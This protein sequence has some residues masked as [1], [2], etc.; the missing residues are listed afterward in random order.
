VGAAAAGADFAAFEREPFVAAFFAV[1]VFRAGVVFLDVAEVPA[2]F[3]AQRFFKAATIAALPA[4]LIFRLGFLA[5]GVAGAGDN[6]NR[7][8][9]RP[10]PQQPERESHQSPRYN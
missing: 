2:L 4:L 10:I 5:S 9:L 6:C 1:V 7:T 3:A 8:V